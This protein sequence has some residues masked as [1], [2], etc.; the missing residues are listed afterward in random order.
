[1]MFG[2][3][4]DHSVGSR[5]VRGPKDAVVKMDMVHGRKNIVAGQASAHIGAGSTKVLCASTD[6][7]SN[8]QQTTT[9]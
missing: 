5:Y 3:T 9:V 2:S 8:A 1:M 6:E 4:T 7:I